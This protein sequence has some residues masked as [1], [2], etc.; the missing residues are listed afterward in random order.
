MVPVSLPA[1]ISTRRTFSPSF[2]ELIQTSPR[3]QANYLRRICGHP[4]FSTFVDAQ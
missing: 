3:S 4:L 1:Y 2:S